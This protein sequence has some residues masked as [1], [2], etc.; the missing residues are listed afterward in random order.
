SRTGKL[1]WRTSLARISPLKITQSRYPRKIR[2]LS[3]TPLVKEGVV[4][5]V[6]NAGIVA[7]LDAETGETIWLT[8]YPQNKKILD[9]F[10]NTGRIWRNEPPMIRGNKLYVTPVDCGLLM[11]LDT[12]N[13]RVLWSA[14]QNTDSFWYKGHRGGQKGY[15][16]MMRMNGFTADGLLVLSWGDLA[17]LNPD[18]GQLAWR[19]RLSTG[20]W[21]EGG[22]PRGKVLKLTGKPPAGLEPAINGE[23]NDFWW[24]MG[25]VASPP[26]VT[27]D[28][29][30]HFS[31]RSYDNNSGGIFYSDYTLDLKAKEITDQRRWF[32]GVHNN[33]PV[34][35]QVVNEEPEIFKPSQRMTFKRWGVLFE[36]DMTTEHIVVRYDR[37]KL[38]EILATRDDLNTL[39]AKAE[40]ARKNEDV[41]GAIN[42]YERCKPLLPSE[43]EDRRKNINL[44]LYPLYTELAR[45]GHESADLPFLEAAAKKMG[46][47]ASNP[48]Q[49]VKAL[50]AYAELHEK[51]GDWMKAVQVLQNASRHYWREPLAVSGLELGDREKLMTTAQ[52]SLE[53]VLGDIPAPYAAAAK[54]LFEAEKI[55]L[56]DYFLAVANVDVDYVVETRSVMA[57][58][59]RELLARAPKDF[60]EKYESRAAEELKKYESVEVGERL[61][62]CW[63]ESAAAKK[64]IRELVAKTASMKPVE[65]QGQ[66]WRFDDLAQACGLGARLVDEGTKG[67]ARASVPSAMPS[68]AGMRQAEAK[69]DD[70]DMVRLV[71]PQ[72]GETEKTAHLLFVGGR[73]KRAY[74]NRFTVMCWN[75]K[76]NKKE[77][78]SR[79]ILLHGKMVGGEGYEVGFEEVFIYDNLALLHGQYDVLAIN[80]TKGTDLDGKGKKEKKWHFRVPLGFEIKS[81]DM[82]GDVLVLCGRGST[83]AISPR[84]GEI[85]WEVSEMGEYYA[86]P[87]FHKD[88][89]FTVRKSPA[90]VSFRK[91]GTGRLL[92][93]LRLPGLTTN[94]K[95]PLYALEG[96]NQN[97]AAAEAAEEYPVAFADG[98][99]AMSDGLS[100]H[101]VDVDKRNLR[102]SRAATKLDMSQEASYR[103]WIEGGKL[104]VLKP[105]YAVIENAVFDLASGDLLWRRREGG[106]KMD[107]KLRKFVAQD[108]A[109]GKAATGLVL[110]SMVFVDGGAYGIKYEM[111]AAAVTLVG[112]DPTTGN[113]TM[114]IREKGYD[115]PE[116]YVEPSWSKGC[117]AVRIQD[118]NKFEVWQVDVKAKKIVQKLELPGYGRLGEYGDASA[119]W[120]GPHQAVWAFDKRKLTT[121]SAQE[122][123]RE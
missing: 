31:M 104:L 83:V 56:Q 74:G 70:P 123:R 102:W 71:L 37:P 36:A 3:T 53:N 122:T 20:E 111:G 61:L 2:I 45:W 113:E 25:V 40:I 26:A 101:V 21:L 103:M 43:E 99:L 82:C 15:P 73:K 78:E 90:E 58:R 4:Y 19:A 98:L 32:Q 72:K 18:T 11:C 38:E 1:L 28:N 59:L 52:R 116:A 114:Q 33:L 95:H 55:T 12:E 22:D 97:P 77:W 57:K 62:W 87:F 17:F 8:R 106:K 14:T 64:K 120:Q 41:Q 48:N 96:A 7:A 117:V 85:V 39:F 94:R 105:Y 16:H 10:S 107:A 115:E 44:R 13:G 47:T 80:Y 63:P 81:V 29:K 109:S 50:L 88:T 68:G 54:Q 60:R 51:K 34:A 42:L 24:Y 66:R 110:G 9:N 92:C 76:D 30:V 35:K 67:L 89:A 69:N 65:R 6:T 49:E 118:G 79:E 108:T 75:M 93:R 23:G 112:M 121:N 46:A 100:Y 119:V 86:G 84:T 91:V 5:H 27:R